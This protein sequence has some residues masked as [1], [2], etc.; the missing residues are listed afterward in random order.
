MAS[1]PVPLVHGAMEITFFNTYLP[2][3]PSLLIVVWSTKRPTQAFV[4]VREGSRVHMNRKE[5]T[6]QGPDSFQFFS[7]SVLCKLVQ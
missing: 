4:I 5:H 6:T 2:Q 3:A 7:A 1:V